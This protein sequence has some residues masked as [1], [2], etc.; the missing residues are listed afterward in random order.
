MS[1][2]AAYQWLLD[3]KL[4]P[5]PK[6]IQVALRFLGV[7]EVVGKGSNPTIIGWRDALNK[8]GHKIEG[9]SDDDVPWC[10]L[11]VAYVCFAAG[12]DVQEA[13]L[14]ARN[15]AKYGKEVATLKNGKLV[16][17][18]GMQPSLG[19]V[20][21]YSRESGGHVEFYIGET[22]DAF[23]GIGGNK[24]NKVMISGIAKS[25]CIA[26][27]RP[28]MTVPPASMKPYLLTDA[29]KLSTNEA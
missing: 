17:A 3:K 2:P 8:A 28:A 21:V 23:V 1:I 14:W 25:R 20:L 4:E 16:N 10:G 13:P 5:L 22:K 24:S 26:V 29:G 18:P 11:F 9:F 15:W 19:D 12:K 6:T 27:R 7:T